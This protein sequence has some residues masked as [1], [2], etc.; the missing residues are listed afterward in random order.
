MNV[1]R[2]APRGVAIIILASACGDVGPSSVLPSALAVSGGNNQTGSAGLLLPASLQVTLTGTDGRPFPDA[3][4]TWQVTSGGGSVSLGSATTDADGVA[5]TH[6]TLGQA[7]GLNL[8]SATVTGVAPVSF[9]ATAVAGPSAEISALSGDQQTAARSAALP[10]PIVVGVVD[11]FGNPVTNTTVTFAASEGSFNVSQVLTDGQGRAQAVWT[12]GTTLGDQTA[13]A[14]TGALAAVTFKATAFDPCENAAALVYAIGTTANGS[15]AP[16]DCVFADGSFADLY[17]VHT[18]SF[19]SFRVDLSSNG[20]DAFLALHDGLGNFVAFND[21][22]GGTTNSAIRILARPDSYILAANSFAGGEIGPYTLVSAAVPAEVGACQHDVH[23]WVTQG[24]QTSQQVLATA[25]VNPSGAYYDHFFLVL[26]PG[27]TVT[28]AMNST[29]FD[30]VLQ[31]LDL[32]SPLDTV[33]AS[34]DNSGGGTN[35]LLSYTHPASIATTYAVWAATSAQGQTGPY[36]LSIAIAQAQVHAGAPHTIG[37]DRD[38]VGLTAPFKPSVK[39]A[40]LGP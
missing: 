27:Q 34:D 20:F 23:V 19:E 21:D 6:L 30:A 17:S 31:L 12:L 16:T 40:L 7:V 33:V 39:R 15:L 4:V 25:C 22:A 32:T 1:L 37:R 9:S 11:Q 28:L 36:T 35:A 13:T 14:T 26:Y 29:A 3:P 10:Q 8:V 2:L 18:T 24:I 5:S 38:A